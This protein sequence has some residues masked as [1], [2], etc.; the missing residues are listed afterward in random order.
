[1]EGAGL[2]ASSHADGSAKGARG[3]YIPNAMLGRI[4]LG[5]FT[6]GLALWIV[7][8]NIAL[9]AE[10][11]GLLFGALLVGLAIEPVVQRLAA[12]HIPRALG[13]VVLYLVLIGML[14]GLGELLVPLFAAE[15]SSLQSQGPAFWS[16]V[17]T[18][19]EGIPLLGQLIPSQGDAVAALTQR[20]DT[21][22]Q[23]VLDTVGSLGNTSVDIGVVFLLAYFG[24]V[25]KASFVDLLRTWVPSGNRA[26]IARVASRILEGLGHWVRAQ[27]LLVLYFAI[28]F[29]TSLAILKVPF[30]L[31]IGLT[32][33]LLSII[34]V[35][36]GL[37][38]TLLGILSALTVKPVL[39]LWVLLIFVALMELEI[40]LIAPAIFGRALRLHPALVLTAMLVGSKAGGLVGLLY[41][42][43]LAV[44]G[45]V[46]LDELRSQWMRTSLGTG[47]GDSPAGIAYESKVGS[48]SVVREDI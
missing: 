15:L 8:R 43:P 42:I 1:M 34:P 14:L 20:M 16:T 24:V 46:F 22:V 47:V 12:W 31:A 7:L 29:S 23:A 25:S 10:I 6:L 5:I 21:V 38:A 45:M 44:V 28:G 37:I 35:L 32:G 39:V 48:K 19:L 33:G 36:G 11:S 17:S 18:T 4:W 30:A 41:S 3:I 26:D 27:P 2:N 13:V 9:I 40:H